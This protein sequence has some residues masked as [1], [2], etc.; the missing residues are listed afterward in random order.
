MKSPELSTPKKES[1]SGY[2]VEH[3]PGA[4]VVLNLG[5][6]LAVDR[7]VILRIFNEGLVTEKKPD[8][9][10]SLKKISAIEDQDGEKRFYVK[11]KR[12][13]SEA[14]IDFMKGRTKKDPLT[15]EAS[16]YMDMGARHRRAS[17]SNEIVFAPKIKDLVASEK[18]QKLAREYG[19]ASLS[20]AEPIVSV[21]E[22]TSKE[23]YVVYRNTKGVNVQNKQIFTQVAQDLGKLFLENGVVSYDL[24]WFD[25]MVIKQDDKYHLV[26]LDTEAYAEGKSPIK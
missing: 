4:D 22:K 3:L 11:N 25:F 23:K 15:P 10:E 20:F 14:N 12:G 19:Y 2:K 18:F 21:I 17:V 6:P 8:V 7:D 26:L 16:K 13:A 5:Y 24:K 1:G 9:S